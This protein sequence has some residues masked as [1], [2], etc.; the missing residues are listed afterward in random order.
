MIECGLLSGE[1]LA[2]QR[3]WDRAERIAAEAWW[4]ARREGAASAWALS[5]ND[6]TRWVTRAMEQLAGLR[7]FL[8]QGVVFLARRGR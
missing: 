1:P 7:A 6:L 8:V 5:T 3:R 2:Y 4:I